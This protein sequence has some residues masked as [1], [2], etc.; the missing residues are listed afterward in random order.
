MAEAATRVALLARPG[1]ACDRLQTALRDAGADVVMVADPTLANADDVRAAGA[2]A[3]LVALEP[4][5]EDAL[6]RFDGLLDDPA[7]TVIFDEAD[8]A[9]R[10]EGW[11][12]ARWVRH[13]AAKLT[14]ASEVLPP[15]GEAEL[16]LGSV[17][18][19]APGTV[20]LHQYRDTGDV[21]SFDITVFETN[22]LN[23]GD[24]D[25]GAFDVG[26]LA[27]EFEA[28]AAAMPDHRDRAGQAA[29]QPVMPADAAAAQE[30]ARAQPAHEQP[31]PAE[32]RD[33][34][35]VSD[36]FHRDL[37]ELNVRIA[38]M[39]LVDAPRHIAKLSGAV[40]VLAGIGGPDAVRQL[41]GGLP[42]TFPRPVLIQ[43]RLDGARHDKLVRQMQRAT[44]MPVHLAAHGD[45]L[46]PGNVYIL[47]EALGVIA[48]G[49]EL[50][51]QQDGDLFA[52]LPADDSAVIVLSGSDPA[53]ADAAMGLSWG[54]ALVAGQMPEG[55]YDATAAEA[56]I[57]RG[58]TSGAPAEL[59]KRLAQRWPA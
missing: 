55:C 5:I 22:T 33:D 45:T 58:A 11:D 31:A 41:L 47:P 43:Q 50:K 10:R 26:D 28:L 34:H 14:G 15:G 27:K 32:A 1:N 8:L 24:S 57:A 2:Q 52:S 20:N 9:A 38:S 17:P 6:E 25:L 44:T 21:G 23:S 12:A 37:E 49:N 30:P 29:S 35:V 54:G 19:I 53:A 4:S 18:A 42:A 16:V 51:F 3:I 7:I 39:E 48:Q 13:L 36:R 56:V 46:A 40:L 59:A